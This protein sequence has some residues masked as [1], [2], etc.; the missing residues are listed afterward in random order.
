MHVRHKKS[1]RLESINLMYLPGK[2]LTGAAITKTVIGDV[3][4][5]MTVISGME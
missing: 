3:T 5:K 2:H 4:D 1:T